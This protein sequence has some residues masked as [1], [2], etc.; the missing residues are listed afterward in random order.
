MLVYRYH[1]VNNPPMPETLPP[2]YVAYR[3]W[4]SRP[5][6]AGLGVRVKGMV[7]YP[8]QLSEKEMN[9][10]GLLAV[11]VLQQPLFIANYQREAQA[12][13]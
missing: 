11:D 1:C 10:Y 3:V 2:G 9:T 5:Y 13:C 4:G 12:L 8:Y 6:M 7:D